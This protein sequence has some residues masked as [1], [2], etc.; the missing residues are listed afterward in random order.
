MKSA[1]PHTGPVSVCTPP[2]STITSPSTER[3][4]DKVSGEIEPLE[5]AYSAPA[6][7]ANDPGDDERRP[8]LR[9]HV[10]ADRFGAQRRIARARNA[11]PNGDATMRQRAA[12]PSAAQDQRQRSNRPL[13]EPSQAPARSPTRPLEPPVIASHWNA[14]DHTICAN[15]SVS[16]AR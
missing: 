5:N 16:I 4:T 14:T 13:R 15:A 7:P 10:D 6:S 8:L 2:S 1:A 12:M 3:G 9:A 11:W